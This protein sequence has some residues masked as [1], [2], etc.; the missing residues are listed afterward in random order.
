MLR[1]AVVAP[2]HYLEHSV[3]ILSCKFRTRHFPSS[4]LR[5]GT[6]AATSRQYSPPPDAQWQEDTPL[7]RSFDNKRSSNAKTTNSRKLTQSEHE[8]LANAFTT[9][10]KHYGQ[11]T[12]LAL[13]KLNS[14]T[15]RFSTIQEILQKRQ[16]IRRVAN[17]LASSNNPAACIRLLSLAVAYGHSLNAP[18][19]EGICWI[20]AQRRS[21]TLILEICRLAKDDLGTMTSRLLD[22][23]LRAFCELENFMAVDAMLQDYVD[24]G[25][26]PSRRTWHWVL[27]AHLR[28]RNLAAARQC[29]QLMEQAGFPADPNTHA[30]I[31][32]NY[33]RL[34]QDTQV[35]EFALSALVSL[36]PSSQTFMINQLLNTHLVF[37]DEAGFHQL[38]SLFDQIAL[39]PLLYLPEK[40]GS[41]ES[42]ANLSCSVPLTPDVDTFLIGV[43]FC[44][45]RSDFVT[46]DKIFTFMGQRG[47]EASPLILVAF[48]ELQFALNRPGFAVFITS[49]LLTPN[50]FNNIYN[51]LQRSGPEH[52]WQW[53]FANSSIR[54][55]T[56]VLNS[57]MRG[58][59]VDQGLGAARIILQLMERVHVQPNS[60]TLK[61]LINYL[62]HTEKAS[63]SLVLRMLRQ[64]SPLLRPSLAHL[65]AIMGG[66]IKKEK[67]HLNSPRRRPDNLTQDAS[68]ARHEDGDDLTNPDAG[69]KLEKS[70]GKPNLARSLLQ[71]L[72][73]RGISSDAGMLRLRM[74]YEGVIKRDLSS[75]I[76]VYND[77]LARGMTPQVY[78]VAALLEAFTL[79][80]KTDEA[81]EVMRTVKLKPNLVLYT[82]L[83]QGYAYQGRPRSAAELFQ[84]MVAEGIKPDVR[85]ISALCNAFIYVGQRGAARKVLVSMWTFVQPFP[86]EY[87]GLRLRMLL[88][89]FRS[90]ENPSSLVKRQINVSNRGQL[91]RDVIQIARK[92]KHVAGLPRVLAPN[93][94]KVRQL[95]KRLVHVSRKT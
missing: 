30:I 92:Y 12:K 93:S 90:L 54:P 63:P 16:T 85:A 69:L 56:D 29:L 46:A 31:A 44:M 83:L 64:I 47:L 38:L 13:Q 73:S 42:M 18:L 81:L 51:R 53:P 40:K 3:G 15:P 77:M 26:K 60:Y 68:T 22:W 11:T 41:S 21:F 17:H 34:G 32:A 84:V 61:V 9:F 67:T 48:L 80:G 28:N 82:I 43:R 95:R 88:E 33:R 10:L 62:I 79:Q 52:G 25:V 49:Q 39:G 4:Y 87:A 23:R 78:H 57:L 5:W 91:Q 1:R 76:D 8:H 71:S 50:K 45:S 7:E 75:T 14:G 94:S 59:L 86:P 19:Y 37:G 36:S 27:A 58:L 20:L 70:L 74:R 24:A 89:I 6:V 2:R 35:R 66:L 72:E 55:T 65:H